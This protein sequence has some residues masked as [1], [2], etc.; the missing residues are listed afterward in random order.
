MTLGPR[1]TATILAALR[2][3]QEH[4]TLG[5]VPARIQLIAAGNGQFEPMEEHEVHELGLQLA[6]VPVASQ[7]RAT[8]RSP[9]ELVRVPA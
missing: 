4:Q 3:M 9:I 5:I 7:P 8:P 1:E 2:L 6:G